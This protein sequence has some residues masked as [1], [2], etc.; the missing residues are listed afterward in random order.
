MPVQTLPEALPISIACRICGKE[1]K[2]ISV[3]CSTENTVYGY[4][5][6]KG[7]RRKLVTAGGEISLLYRNLASE[8]FNKAAIAE[9]ADGAEALTRMGRCYIA[10]ASFLDPSPSDQPPPLLAAP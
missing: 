8:C 2:L 9:Q 10:E 3:E 7:H 5:C 1:M 4:Q 6:V